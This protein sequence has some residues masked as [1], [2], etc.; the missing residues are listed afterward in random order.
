MVLA[1]LAVACSTWCLMMVENLGLERRKAGKVGQHGG[2][3]S[4]YA[5]PMASGTAPAVLHHP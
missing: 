3:C 5:E 2:H 1:G 4:K